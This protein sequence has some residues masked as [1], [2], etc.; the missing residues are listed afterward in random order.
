MTPEQASL[1]LGVPLI[2]HSGSRGSEIFL[3]YGAAG[4]P[5][6]YPVD[7]AIALHFR[8]GVLTG[9][10]KDWRLRRPGLF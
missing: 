5:G 2:Y 10:K 3:A 4:V 1:S 7:S 6:P 9:W 8:K